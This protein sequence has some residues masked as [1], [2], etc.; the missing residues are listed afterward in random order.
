MLKEA[1]GNDEWSDDELRAA[2]ASYKDM[3]QRAAVGEPFTKKAYYDALARQFGRSAK[4]FEYRMQNISYVLTLLGR[5]WLA[6]LKPKQNVGPKNAVKIEQFL[7][8]IEGLP[9]T[10]VAEFEFAVRE[11]RGRQRAPPGGITRPRVTVS[12]VAVFQ[13][14]PAV[15]AWVLDA[16]KGACECCQAPAPFRDTSGRPFLEVHHVRRLADRGSDRISNAVALCPNCH[17]ALH[18]GERAKELVAH[19]FSTVERLVAE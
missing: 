18:H 11:R 5:D 10:H 7:G 13:R 9:L 19:L 1:V 6:G 16:A 14:D 4:A 17:R 15:K 2:V 12:P 3:Q 8:E